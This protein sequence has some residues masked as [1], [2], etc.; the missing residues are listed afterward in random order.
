MCKCCQLQTGASEKELSPQNER[1]SG[2]PSSSTDRIPQ[3]NI[4]MRKHRPHRSLAKNCNGF[5]LIEIIAVLIILSVIGAITVPRVVALDTF[6]TQKS[7][8][9]AISELNGRE[10]MT[11]SKIKTLGSNWVGDEQ[12]FAEVNTDLGAEYTWSSKTTG[13]GTLHF[14]G[15]QTVIERIPSTCSQSGTWRLK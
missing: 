7:F 14:R 5:T 10:F 1:P 15:Q 9:R 8:E 4:Y 11:W 2:Q 3:P 6:A 12:L 13:G